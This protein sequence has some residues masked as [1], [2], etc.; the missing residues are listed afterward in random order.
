[1]SKDKILKGGEKPPKKERPPK[2]GQQHLPGAEQMDKIPAIHKAATEYAKLRDH[3]MAI[4]KQEVEAKSK[5]K[6]LMDNKGIKVYEHGDVHVNIE[7]T[8]KIKV[9]IGNEHEEDEEG[10]DAA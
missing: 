2:G 8:E 5:V 6:L 7:N 9:K 10:D 4:L 1:M 3:R